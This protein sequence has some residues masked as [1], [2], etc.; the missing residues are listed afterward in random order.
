MTSSTIC[1]NVQNAIQAWH[2]GKCPVGCE[3]LQNATKLDMVTKYQYDPISYIKSLFSDE[4]AKIR[5]LTIKN[6]KNGL[7]TPYIY[8]HQFIGCD[9]DGF[10]EKKINRS[11]IEVAGYKPQPIIGG[12]FLYKKLS[13]KIINYMPVW[14]DW[15]M[16]PDLMFIIIMLFVIIII[17][18]STIHYIRIYKHKQ[19]PHDHQL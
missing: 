15:I 7:I 13:P 18:L 2:K 4:N 5:N 11:I 14:V 8:W 3:L 12:N 1:D 9:V 17:I 6:L 19:Q 16:N 10:V